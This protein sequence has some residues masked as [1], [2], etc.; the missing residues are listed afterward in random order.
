[1]VVVVALAAVVLCN[2]IRGRDRLPFLSRMMLD[3][4]GT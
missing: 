2:V 3:I 1:M 4:S